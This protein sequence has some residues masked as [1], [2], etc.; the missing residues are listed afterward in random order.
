MTQLE[1]FTKTIEENTWP[2]EGGS[3]TRIGIFSAVDER[4]ARTLS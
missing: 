4:D 2:Y 3:N 1:Y